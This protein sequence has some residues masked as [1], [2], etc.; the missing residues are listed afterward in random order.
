MEPDDEGRGDRPP[1]FT[2]RPP[3]FLELFAASL[4]TGIQPGMRMVEEVLYLKAIVEM[5]LSRLRAEH[6]LGQVSLR[7]TMHSIQM[8][9]VRM[10]TP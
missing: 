4:W 2:P 10:V 9:E 6:A 7:N 1:A 5:E 8:T 3:P